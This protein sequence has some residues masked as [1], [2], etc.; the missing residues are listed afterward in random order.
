MD[1]RDD[2]MKNSSAKLT[3]DDFLGFPDDGLRHELIDGEHYV[4]P[5]PN[6]VHQRLVGALHIAL[7]NYLVETKRGEVFFAPFDVVLSEHDVV[8]PDLLVVLDTQPD[9]LTEKHVR[10]A[11]GIVIEVLSPGTRRRDET[12]KRRL[13]E[14][15]GVAEYWIVDPER[16]V[17]TLCRREGATGPWSASEFIAAR[18]DELASQVLPGFALSLPQLFSSATR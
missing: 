10:G 16:A 15:V 4:T 11:P 8:A 17:I 9:I 3:Y 1:G 6:T 12:I 18:G 7:H 13:Y 2:I 14:R 5:S